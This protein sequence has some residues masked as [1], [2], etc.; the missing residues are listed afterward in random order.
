MELLPSLAS[1]NQMALG[2]AL[3]ALGDWP[4]W[5]AD[6]EDGNFVPNITFG[7]KLLRQA[8]RHAPDK[9]VDVHLMVTNP[10]E[11]LKPLAEMGVAAVCAH[12]E[13]LPYPLLFLNGAR[14]L[15][16]RA[17]LAFNVRLPVAAA[18]P[19]LGAT[20]YLMMMTAEPDAAG[21]MLLTS[22]LEKAC[23][24]AW[25]YHTPVYAD[26]GLTEDA[27]RVLREAGAAGCVLGRF[28]FEAEEPLARLRAL[29]EG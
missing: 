29:E 22:A 24:A 15:G 27:V 20:D 8:M 21:E 26:G 11:Y 5:H 3:D 16:M 10:L 4:C 17:G 23:G 14:K 2:K 7:L 13:V 18:E 19:F 28:V 9:R 12:L 25:T 6:I 1:A